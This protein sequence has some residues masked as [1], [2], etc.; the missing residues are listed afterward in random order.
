MSPDLIPILSISSELA[1][2]YFGDT[3]DSLWKHGLISMTAKVFQRWRK[4]I[5]DSNEQGQGVLVNKHLS[6]EQ[7][8][9]WGFITEHII[10]WQAQDKQGHSRSSSLKEIAWCLIQRWIY[11][12]WVL[13]AAFNHWREETA[14]T[15]PWDHMERTILLFGLPFVHVH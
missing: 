12:G 14:H 6:I 3:V 9:Q 7:T 13:D 5:R 2:N 15:S 11:S 1:L 8:Y 4:I 10:Y